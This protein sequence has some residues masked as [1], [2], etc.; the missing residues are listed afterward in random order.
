MLHHPRLVTLALG[1]LAASPIAASEGGGEA[2]PSPP[3]LAALAREA[4]PD[5]VA[6]PPPEFTLKSWSVDDG[7]PQGTPVAI[8]QTRDGFLWVGTFNGLARFDGLRFTAFTTATTPELVSDRIQDLL[9]DRGGDLWIAT[10]GGGLVRYRDGRFGAFPDDGDSPAAEITSLAEGSDGSLWVGT[11]RGLFR[12]SQDRLE[13]DTLSATLSLDPILGIHADPDGSIWVGTPTRV[14]VRR[15]DGEVR[16]IVMP[17]PIAR[18]GADR[19]GSLWLAFQRAGLARLDTVTLS[20]SIETFSS[21][22]DAILESRNGTLWMGTF[23]G[24]LF[25]ATPSSP[26]E[27]QRRV[28]LSSRGVTALYEDRWGNLWAGVN[29]GG[30]WRLREKL[31]RTYGTEHGL[32]TP[33]IASLLRDRDDRLW[34]GTFGKGAYRWEDGRFTAVPV[35][36]N[37]YNITSL[38]ETTDGSLWFGTYG[39][40]LFQGLGDSA[41]KMHSQAGHGF[42][43]LLADRRGGLWY[44]WVRGGC[45]HYR[46]GQWVAHS[47]RDGLPSDFVS[48]FAQDAHGDIWVGTL[49]GVSRHRDGRFENF[50]T[51]DGLGGNQVRALHVDRRG[52]LWIGSSGGGLSRYANGRFQAVGRPDG[53]IHDRI[54]QILE[55]D[56]GHLW[57][58][59]GAGIMRLSQADLDDYFAGERGPLQPL[60]LGSEEG[61]IR[62]ECGSGFQPSCL[63]APDGRLWFATGDGVVV[64]DPARLEHRPGPPPVHLEE[65]RVDG[66]LQR[67]VPA[68]D[69][70]ESGG[71][72][73]SAAPAKGRAFRLPAGSRRLEFHFTA[74]DLA[75]PRWVRFR[76]RLEGFDTD[77]VETGHRREATYTQVPPGRY[78]FVVTAANSPGDWNP[79]VAAATVEILPFFWQ[80]WTFRVGLGGVTCLAVWRSLVWLTARRERRA[81]LRAE[82]RQ[83]LERERARIAHDMHDGLG[84]SLVRISML[85]D[86][87]EH[88]LGQVDQA[89]DCIRRMS[90]TA[91]EAARDMDEIVWA[92]NPKH[93]TLGSLIGYLSQFGREHFDGTPMEFR[94]DLPPVLPPHPL[95]AEIRH[96]LYLATKET[97]NNV[98]KHSQATEVWMRLRLRDSRL[99][100]IIE[101]NGIGIDAA[102]RPGYGL[103]NVQARL[104]H[105][106][107]SV[108]VETGPG[109]GTCIRF[110]APLPGVPP[111][112]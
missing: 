48:A 70:G 72:A 78:R 77:W 85:G 55:D 100:M 66:R 112:L 42:R 28:R 44:A 20:L 109:R 17:R 46:D 73:G 12:R 16:V 25:S 13:R 37:V 36:A 98:L 22:P 74:V 89:R 87:A 69:Q 14:V 7:L 19:R 6:G 75:A 57:L 47:T 76:H 21:R 27:F 38:A 34:V 1:L 50:T 10:R 43:A 110:L 53:L 63:Q 8:T 84:A 107:G 99:V 65:V 88:R 71:A 41:L 29:G 101:D 33:S 86:L 31:V 18:L 35:G 80:T 92:V 60:V 56:D 67:P 9:E 40:G 11:D 104:R 91:R 102:N 32:G 82:R 103:A 105:I 54:E 90:Q 62:A 49:E 106:Q 83:A 45:G 95:T 23:H 58:G 108:E 96:H 26:T 15:R 97:L 68:P 93:D 5:S 39:G 4:N 64:V 24:Q 94:L 111:A 52:R 79:E 3:G 81:L 2:E 61:M 30:L 59:S 51:K